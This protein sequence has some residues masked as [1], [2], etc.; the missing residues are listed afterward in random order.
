MAKSNETNSISTNMITNGT[1][2][3]GDISCDSDIRIEGEL[4]GSLVAKGKLVIGNS[5]RIKGEVTC[6]N[7]DVEGALNGKIIT[8]ELLSLRE[9]AKI[10]GDIYTKKLAIEPGAI[11]SGTCSMNDSISDNEMANKK[12]IAG[13]E[14]K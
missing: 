13:K 4:E 11:F 1:K 6:Q 12:D 8:H 7:C 5:G 10:T 2:I 14:K 3:T 9:T